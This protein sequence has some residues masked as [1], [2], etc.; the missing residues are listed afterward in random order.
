M[1]KL[2]FHPNL[3]ATN[4]YGFNGI[5]PGPTIAA[6][7]NKPV[8]VDWHSRLSNIHPLG[9]A[10]DP[11]LANGEIGEL[12]AVR[13]TIHNHGAHVLNLSDGL[14]N[15][16][17][18]PGNTLHY[19][20]PNHAPGTQWYHDH[21]HGITQLN[22]YAGLAGFYLV[23]MPGVDEKLGLPTGEYE[24]RSLSRTNSSAR[25]ALY[26]PTTGHGHNP[27][28]VSDLEADIPVAN[29][30]VAPYLQ[31]EPRKYRFHIL[32]WRQLS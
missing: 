12:P 7:T 3:P 6:E 9:Y 24:S 2:I 18:T 11:T 15:D 29:G 13:N 19:R 8:K 22:V 1:I 25:M 10:I 17:I 4:M 30:K 26:Y 16:W 23:R 32:K 21:I 27:I 31:V 5:H 20:Y 28:W 14:P